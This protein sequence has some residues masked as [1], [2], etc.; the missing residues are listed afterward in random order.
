MEIVGSQ[1]HLPTRDEYGVGGI[2]P[3]LSKSLHQYLISCILEKVSDESLKAYRLDQSASL[4]CELL[5]PNPNQIYSSSPK[6]REELENDK[7]KC[8]K[9]ILDKAK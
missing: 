5:V 2:P 1:A 4:G 9:A 3:P 8:I 7:N 6:K